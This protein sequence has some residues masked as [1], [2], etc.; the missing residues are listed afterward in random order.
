MTSIIGY[1]DM[2]RSLPLE[3]E[4]ITDYADYIYS[5]AKRLERLS[6]NMLALLR[7]PEE[8][9]LFQAVPVQSIADTALLSLGP[10]FLRDKIQWRTDPLSET[11]NTASRLSA[12]FSPENA[13]AG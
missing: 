8:E 3:E 1:A 13:D 2:I 11:E 6:Q 9:L 4:E 5:Q 7:L 10:A 12:S